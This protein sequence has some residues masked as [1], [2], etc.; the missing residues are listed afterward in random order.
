MSLLQKLNERRTFWVKGWSGERNVGMEALSLW[1][2]LPFP[3]GFQTPLYG[4][5][6]KGSGCYMESGIHVP[7]ALF[8]GR[9]KCVKWYPPWWE[10]QLVRLIWYWQHLGIFG[11]WLDKFGMFL[12]ARSRSLKSDWRKGVWSRLFNLSF[13]HHYLCNTPLSKENGMQIA[14]LAYRMK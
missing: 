10:F 1:R 8:P 3:G 13:S 2:E 11:E 7:G 14:M 4:C 6:C 12:W 5:F 9:E